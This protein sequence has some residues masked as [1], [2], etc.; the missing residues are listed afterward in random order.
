MCAGCEWFPSWVIKVDD[1][2]TSYVYAIIIYDDDDGDS[3]KYVD[4][5]RRTI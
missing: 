5:H 3:N 1:A 2:N 4:E